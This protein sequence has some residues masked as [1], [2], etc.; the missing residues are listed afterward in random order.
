MADIRHSILINAPSEKIRPLFSSA[1]G[2]SQWW[3]EDSVE[4]GNDGSVALGFFSRNTLYLLRPGKNDPNEMVWKCESGKEWNGTTL[5][6]SLEPAGQS[7]QLRFIHG[8]WQGETDYFMSC[9]TTWGELMYR[10]KAVAE[11][12][13]PGPLFSIDGLAY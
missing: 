4:Q 13:T 10:L 12:K 11:G 3:V 9:N 1:K 6:F 7:T 5:Q 2:F 8:G